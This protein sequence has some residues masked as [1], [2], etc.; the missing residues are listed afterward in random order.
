MFTRNRLTVRLRIEFLCRC[1]SELAFYLITAWT[2]V[3]PLVWPQPPVSGCIGAALPLRDNTAS[4]AMS[5][6]GRFASRLPHQLAHHL[7]VISDSMLPFCQN[8]FS[9]ERCN[10]FPC[11][12]ICDIIDL[13]LTPSHLSGLHSNRWSG[14]HHFPQSVSLRKCASCLKK[15]KQKKK[16]LALKQTSKDYF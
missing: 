15:K 2:F 16:T 10:P 12:S 14:R 1:L 9:G 8:G 4:P 3:D 5:R 6:G 13:I 11:I 7:G